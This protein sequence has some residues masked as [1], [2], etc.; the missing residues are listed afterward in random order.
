MADLPVKVRWWCAGITLL[1]ALGLL[2]PAL[3]GTVRAPLPLD[4]DQWTALGVI[5]LFAAPSGLLGVSW[6]VL[7]SG[8]RVALRAAAALLGLV[9]LLLYLPFALASVLTFIAAWLVAA[10][11]RAA[12]S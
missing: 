6:L 4:R 5:L 1:P 12:P 10:R 8:P 11:S 3:A 9:G 2:L 7:P